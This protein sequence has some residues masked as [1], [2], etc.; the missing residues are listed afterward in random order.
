MQDTDQ[1]DPRAVCQPDRLRV[2]V[3]IESP[4]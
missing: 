1:R 2:V 3:L 4:K